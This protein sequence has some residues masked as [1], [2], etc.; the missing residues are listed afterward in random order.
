MFGVLCCCES[1]VSCIVMMSMLWF[2]VRCSI[3]CILFLRPFMFICSMFSV[4]VF[5]GFVLLVVCCV[6]VVVLL[7]FCLVGFAVGVL[8]GCVWGVCVVGV[9]FVVPV[10]V[11]WVCWGQ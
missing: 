9:L 8:V 5:R 4:F 2:C 10:V 7:W 3:S 11:F 6:E 1:F